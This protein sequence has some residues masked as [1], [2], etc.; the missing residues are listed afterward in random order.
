MMKNLSDASSV[1]LIQPDARLSA[2]LAVG[3]RQ[4]GM[5][6]VKY[7]SAEAALAALGKGHK[8]GVLVT[9]P[10]LGRMTNR[11]FVEQ[12]KAVAPR[13]IIVFTPPPAAADGHIPAEDAHILAG[14]LDV[15]KLSR[16]LRLITARPAPLGA[17]QAAYRQTRHGI[18][19]AA[20]GVAPQAREGEAAQ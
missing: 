10:A 11:E 18:G 2:T 5:R 16:F 8:A 19:L 9:A 15:V 1:W 17:L 4:D 7:G 14:P 12:A 6:V 3:L 13:V 20:S